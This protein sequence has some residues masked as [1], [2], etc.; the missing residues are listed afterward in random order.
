MMVD[1]ANTVLYAIKEGT[2]MQLSVSKHEIIGITTLEKVLE[3][4]LNMNILDEKDREKIKSQTNRSVT[5][6]HDDENKGARDIGYTG[7]NETGN[8]FN[9]T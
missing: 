1:E 2:D 6:I 4:I 9:L 7:M 8:V 3:E 5:L